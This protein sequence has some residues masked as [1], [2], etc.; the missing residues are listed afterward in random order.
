MNIKISG[1]DALFSRY[2]RTRDKWTCQR[3]HK[4]YAPPTSALHCSHVFSRAKQ[5]VRFALENAESLCYGCHSYFGRNPLKHYAWYVQ[6]HGQ[7]AFDRLQLRA[8][9]PRKVDRIVTKLWLQ[10]GLAKL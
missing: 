4:V 9:Q 5:S 1:L 8:N 3:C 2:I 10:Q 7:A 6:K